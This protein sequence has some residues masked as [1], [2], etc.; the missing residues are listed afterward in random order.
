MTLDEAVAEFESALTVHDEIGHS[1]GAAYDGPMD[2][3]RAPTGERYVT[4]T[5]GGIKPE[6]WPNPAWFNSKDDAVDFWLMEAKHYAREHGTQLY[7]REK[8]EL[9]GQTFVAMN[10]A[11]SLQS[12]R[13]REAVAVAVWFVWS[14]LL[15]SK[16]DPSGHEVKIQ[17]E[18]T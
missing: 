14:R 4:L 10:Q 8:P 7:W 15:V 9:E 11:D 18:D 16:K 3:S 13:L 5:S 6:G 17:S 1:A 2:F 12:Q